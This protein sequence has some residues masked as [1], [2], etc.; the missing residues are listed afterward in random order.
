M[1]C[2]QGGSSHC[3]ETTSL[4]TRA[5][6]PPGR[7]VPPPTPQERP[8]RVEGGSLSLGSCS[9][10]SRS[11]NPG[12]RACPRS[13]RLC[14]SFREL[15]ISICAVGGGAGWGYCVLLERD[16][17]QGGRACRPL[18]TDVAALPRI[19]SPI[20]AAPSGS[21]WASTAVLRETERAGRVPSGSGAQ[22]W[23]PGRAWGPTVPGGAPAPPPCPRDARLQW[24]FALC[25][26]P[27]WPSSVVVS[28]GR[29]GSL[30]SSLATTVGRAVPGETSWAGHPCP[31]ACH[32][33]CVPGV[34]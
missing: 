5:H 15:F 25:P 9:Q 7:P 1:A 4:P 14:D 2:L 17:R 33:S 27:C 21:I 22:G 10:T 12:R 20:S 6:S 32:L 23:L 3:S 13:L 24:N 31:S 29:P 8:P 34:S 28:L 30:A 11:G 18:A 16:P 19:T 26:H